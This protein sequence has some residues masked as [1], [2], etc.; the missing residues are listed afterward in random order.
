ISTLVQFRAID[1]GMEHCELHINYP[2]HST[3]AMEH[4]TPITVN[5]LDSKIPLHTKSLSY[6]T[7][8]AV[9]YKISQIE[10]ESRNG[11]GMSWSQEFDCLWDELL[12]FELSYI[13]DHL[14]SYESCIIQ[15]S[16]EKD[17]SSLEAG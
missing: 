2:A 5:K 11:S 17:I 8:P 1:Y 12:I 14:S 16:Q 10:V 7:K 3:C 4:S 6:V 9:E 13:D 15:W